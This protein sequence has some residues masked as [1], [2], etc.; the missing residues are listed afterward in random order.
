MHHPWR[1]LRNRG[2]HVQVHYTRFDDGRAGATSG[3]LIWLE[4]RLLQQER[5]CAVQH[6]QIH[7]ER[8]DDCDDP[9]VERRVRTLTAQ[10]LIDTADLVDAAKWATVPEEIADELNVTLEV[11]ED[12]INALS[13]VE[14]ALIDQAIREA[15]HHD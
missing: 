9:T 7:L 12:R 14:R 10:R 1:E 6:E 13:P 4:Q 3:N 11:L 2:D 15:W 5:R 8:G